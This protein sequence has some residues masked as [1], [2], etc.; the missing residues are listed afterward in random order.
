MQ[1]EFSCIR[2]GAYGW[3]LWVCGK[4]CKQENLEIIG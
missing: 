4:I 2:T 3:H 1:T